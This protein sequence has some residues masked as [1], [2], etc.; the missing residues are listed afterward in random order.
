MMAC[1]KEDEI[2]LFVSGEMNKKESAEVLKH[3]AEC[4]KCRAILKEYKEMSKG[5]SKKSFPPVPKNLHKSIIS[6]LFP[7]KSFTITPFFQRLW[8]K[9]AIVFS[10]AIVIFLIGMQAGMLIKSSDLQ[11]QTES[12]PVHPAIDSYLINTQTLFLD[13][14][15]FNSLNQLDQSRITI[16]SAEQLLEKTR[17][18]KGTL[19]KNN[20]ELNELVIQIENLLEEI[21]LSQEINSKE[22]QNT[23]KEELIAQQILLRINNFIS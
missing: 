18:I 1:L 19:D 9:P 5:I 8:I 4:P 23:I 16:R 7:K 6:N 14:S 13:Y 20:R 2:L 12:V 21:I 22:L 11:I 3:T 17:V 15:N 10:S